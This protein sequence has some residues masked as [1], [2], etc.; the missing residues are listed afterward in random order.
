MAL[1]PEEQV[2]LGP[3][4]V[5][6]ANRRLFRDGV[7]L[8]LR[9]QAFR[10]L[11]VL[12][13]NRGQLVEYPQLIREA[14]A[15]LQ[16]SKHTVAVTVNEVKDAL[17]VYGS[18]ITCRPKL[19]YLLEVP[20]S[21]DFIRRGWHFLN[22]Y[23]RA[24]FENGLRCFQQAAE[25]DSADFRAF[26]GVASAYLMLGGFLMRAPRS[27]GGAFLEAHQRA[28]SLCGLTPELLADR[29]F[30]RIIFE[31]QPAQAEAELLEARK[32]GSTSPH[33]HIRLA[34]AYMALG[35]LD[36]AADVMR[37]AEAGDTLLPELTFTGTLLRLFRRDFDAA[38]RWGREKLDLHPGSQVGRAFYAEALDHAGNSEQALAQYR[39][40]AAMSPDISWIRAQ[41]AR[42]LARHGSSSKALAILQHLQ[43]NRETEYVDAYFLA[44]VLDAL[45]KRGE[46][47]QELERARAENSYALLFVDVDPKADGLKGSSQFG[48]WRGHAVAVVARAC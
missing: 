26:A 20:E 28:V 41:E 12:I 45:G 16:V 36:R 27:I 29:A 42:C 4:R 46:A 34:L 11:K 47:F 22:L 31:G 33:V 40:A 44:L 19:G 25:K 30:G 21:N 37:R 1:A 43:R 5:D 32:V 38:V 7:S 15:G 35:Q 13:D 2:A 9:P 18:W 48:V 3:F 8:E 39:L 10:A 17:G 6:T 24:G 23:T 14:W